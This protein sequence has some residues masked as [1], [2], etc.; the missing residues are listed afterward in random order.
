MPTDTGSIVSVEGRLPPEEFGVTLPH[1][2]VFIDVTEEWYEPPESASERRLA[3]EP[4]SLENLWYVRRHPLGNKDNGRL[5]SES[6]A[7][8]ELTRYHRAG[9]DAV[10]DV[11][12]KG[13]GADPERV[14]GV[15]R[16]TGLTFV[17]GTSYYTAATHP[18]HVSTATVDE[19]ADEF[20]ADVREGIGDTDVRAGLIGEIGLS[21][22]IEPT[23]ERVLRA[24]ARAVVRTGAPLSVHPPGRGDDEHRGGE[25]PS[26]RWELDVLDVVAEEGF[27]ADH[28]VLCHQDRT[29][30]EYDLWGTERY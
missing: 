10:V 2:H 12:P 14:G 19:L 4:V 5:E 15:A 16:E 13:I 17:H 7:V 21:G 3:N 29:P 9:G 28:V 6:D 24:G 26:S 18:E 27:P 20:V 23:E 11:T 30:V 25:Y 8:A 1:E 22:R